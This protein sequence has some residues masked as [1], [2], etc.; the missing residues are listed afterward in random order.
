MHVTCAKNIIILRTQRTDLAG[1]RSYVFVQRTLSSYAH[2]TQIL[3]GTDH[4]CTCEECF[5]LVHA[6]HRSCGGSIMCARARNAIIPPH[7][8]PSPKKWQNAAPVF[9]R[10]QPQQKQKHNRQIKN[11]NNK[12]LFD[13]PHGLHSKFGSLK[14][15]CIAHVCIVEFSACLVWLVFFRQLQLIV[16][17]MFPKFLKLKRP[18][19]M[20]PIFVVCSVS[21]PVF[22]R[23]RK[24]RQIFPRGHRQGRPCLQQC[25]RSAERSVRDIGCL[26]K[27]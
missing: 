12:Y 16:C 27:G 24:H 9:G 7:P 11:K 17:S 25:T 13:I 23:P 3:R 14:Q 2:N 20:V 18:L 10:K 6:T 21:F 22:A 1:D 19:N 15:P 4:M 8:T 26:L 5:L